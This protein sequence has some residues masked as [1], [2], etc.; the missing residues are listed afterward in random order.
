MQSNTFTLQYFVYNV[1]P[2]MI[3]AIGLHLI[4]S[5]LQAPFCA[6]FST[7]LF[8][9]GVYLVAISFA[10][11][12]QSFLAGLFSQYAWL[13]QVEGDRASILPLNEWNKTFQSWFKLLLAFTFF[14]IFP[15]AEF[16]IEVSYFPT[17]K[18][19]RVWSLGRPDILKVNGCID[20]SG[21]KRFL[22]TGALLNT[23]LLA[24]YEIICSLTAFKLPEKKAEN[25]LRPI[26]FA[27]WVKS[28]KL[29]PVITVLEYLL[30]LSS[31]VNRFNFKH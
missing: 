5:N 23:V 1:L 25:N 27:F 19:W 4:N 3:A 18:H 9:V 20:A 15:L 26:S 17:V 29:I 21:R 6:N 31:Q 2:G 11:F 7:E 13:E 12:L 30:L 16:F 14:Y 24:A 28:N 10:L 8:L 22:I